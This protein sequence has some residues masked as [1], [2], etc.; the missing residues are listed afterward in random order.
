MEI[1]NKNNLN[2]SKIQDDSKKG[3]KDAT[4]YFLRGIKH[5]NSGNKEEAEK[6]FNEAVKAEGDRSLAY[7]NR[8]VFY[9]NEKKFTNAIEDFF[10]A[11]KFNNKFAEAFYNI[12]C[13]YVQILSFREGISN[14]K[15]AIKLD[16]NLALQA[17]IDP[18]F[19]NVNKM[20]EFKEAILIT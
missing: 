16:K 3:K 10:S 11:I 8:G 6:D 19:V 1:R 15:K 20:K 7:F 4:F 2:A 17:E 18:D 5:Y 9:L 14:L 12:A 13:C